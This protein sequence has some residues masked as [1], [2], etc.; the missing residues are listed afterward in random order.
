MKRAW[1]AWTPF[2]C[3]RL[4]LILAGVVFFLMPAGS[5]SGQLVFSLDF[6]ADGGDPDGI[7]ETAWPARQSKII[8]ADVYVS[9]V[10]EPGLIS[11]GF[12]I[13]YNSDR[14][15]AVERGTAVDEVNWTSS[16]LSF[17]SGKIDMRGLRD[18]EPWLS[19]DRIRLGK[20]QLR[21]DTEG[22]SELVLTDRP[23]TDDFVLQD[24]TVLDEQIAG[25][26]VL[27]RIHP[28]LA[29]DMNGDGVVEL[30]DAI[31]AFRVLLDLPAPYVNRT[32]DLDADAKIGMAEALYVLQKA[33]EVR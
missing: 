29:G 5:V 20:I 24:G 31:L 1:K 32:A 10:P 18:S 26:I 7:Y 11:M 30:A 4:S 16:N 21:C 17:L 13:S 6:Y 22:V 19:G 25:G 27:A 12:I 33:A 28:G 9:N 8:Q 14:L 3:N 15:L 2:A 23:G